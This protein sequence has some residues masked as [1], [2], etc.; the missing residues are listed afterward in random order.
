MLE[1]LE[2]FVAQQDDA[3]PFVKM[4]KAAAED[5]H[6]EVGLAL[7]T[8]HSQCD[9]TFGHMSAQF[10]SWASEGSNDDETVAAV[11]LG[12]RD[13]V[14]EKDEET[15]GIVQSLMAIGQNPT[16]K[17]K[18]EHKPEPKAE[19]EA[20]TEANLKLELKFNPQPH[21]PIKQEHDE[22]TKA[23]EDAAQS[24]GQ[25]TEVQSGGL[26]PKV[27]PNSPKAKKVKVEMEDE[28]MNDAD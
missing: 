19:P 13:D 4:A 14:I 12:S 11:K 3:S 15:A 2:D 5:I 8:L 22:I 25:E 16:R 7:T 28:V 26:E 21:V 9:N 24:E 17:S 1:L 18:P 27:E 6:K 23:P 10:G 20:E